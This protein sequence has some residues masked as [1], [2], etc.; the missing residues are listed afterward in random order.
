MAEGESDN[1]TME[2]YRALTRGNQASGIVKPKIRGNVNFEIKSQFMREL[3][4]NTFSE[5]KNDDAHEHVERVLDIVS[6]FNIQGVTHDGVML[7]VFPITLTGATKRYYPPSKTAKQLEEICNFKKEGEETLFQSWERYND[8]LYKCPTHD[9]NIHQKLTKEFQAKT[10][11][12]EPNSSVGQC[13]AVYANDEAPIDNK[14]YNGT[15]EVSFIANNKAHV[16]QEE[17]DV[18]IKVLSFQLP[19][20][21]LNPGSFT[22]P[23]TVGILNFFAMAD[24]G[25]SLKVMPKSMFEHL[26]VANRMKTD[27]L[28]EMDDMAN[29]API[30][31]VENVLVMIDMFLFLSDFVVID[32]LN[33]RNETMILE[34][35]FL[36]TIHIE[37][38]VFN[39]E[40][41]L[42]IR[43]DKER[44]SKKARMLKP[45]TNTS[46]DYKPRPRDYPFKE[47]LLTKVG[48]IDVSEPVKKALLK[49]WL[50]NCI[51]E[52]LAKDPRSRIFDDY[53][54]MFD[55]EIYQSAD[56]YEL[57]IGKKGHVLDDIWE[58]E[59]KKKAQLQKDKALNTKPSVQQSDRLPNTANGNKPKTRNFNQQPRNW[60]PSMSSRVSNRIV[61]TSELPRNQKPFLQS[62]DLE[63]STC[64]QCIFS[65]NHDECILK[66][67]SELNSRTS[68]QKKHAQS[69]KKTKRYIP[70][71]KKNNSKNHG[72]QIPIGQRFS[73]N[74]SSNV[75]LKTMPPR[76]GLTWKPTGRIFT[77]VG[78]KWISIRKSVET[79]YNTNNST[80]PL[81]KETHNPKT[82]IC[83]NSSSLSAGTS[84]AYEPISSEGSSN[85]ATRSSDKRFNTIITSLNALDESISSRN[86]VRK[87]LRALLT[88]WRPKDLEI[89]KRK[90]EKYKS[91]ALKERK[92]LSEEEGT[93]SDSDDEEYAMAEKDD[94]RCFKYGDQNH[95][96]SDSEGDCRKEEIC[97]MA[98][99]NSE[100]LSDTPY[101][102]SSSLDNE[103]WEMS[104]INYAKLVL[105]FSKK[106]LK[107]KNKVL[108]RKACELKAKVKQLERYKE[109]SLGCESCVDLQSKISL[110]TLKLA[111]FKN[112][113]SS[114]Q[115]MIEMQK[116][117]K[118]KH[119]LG[120][121]EV[122]AS[123]SS[124]KTKKSSIFLGYSPNSKAYI[125]LNKETMKVEESLNVK[126]DE[127]PPPV[128][129]PLE[130]DDILKCEVIE[131][132]VKD[133]E[134]K[135]NEP[136]NKEIINIKESKAHLLETVI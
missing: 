127:S 103:S 82:V 2:Q 43:D 72:R 126:F 48:H 63:C 106:Q 38:D 68:A 61:N 67:I 114:L 55:L 118:D 95:F 99:D 89:S 131:N 40:I 24:L 111:S 51:R 59:A 26:K 120:Y 75:F 5:N 37:I 16:A 28:V 87:F 64:K 4:E 125:I 71:E 47:W 69:H 105:E 129:P 15:N 41:S 58:N 27:I 133:L 65:A 12:E 85:I 6:L 34:R 1:L 39:K 56:E 49:S 122:I 92:V 124:I 11:S 54:W 44:S 123:S 90:K 10:A 132:K 52:E 46:K 91:L 20:K 78:I 84:M 9:I 19:P 42:G 94:Q 17:D 62:K 76:S 32:M 35:P 7:R 8:L 115:E 36:A 18:L 108:K 3:R 23:C 83:A 66:Y 136:L 57:G 81:G 45:D 22:L 21:E 73:L 135:E 117:P 77:Q 79:R 29:R 25:A 100:V 30:G 86:H 33:I 88:K 53:K 134:I 50:I 70:V 104:M 116:A 109:I 130:D 113:S 96:I 128:S 74:K 119:R 97:L 98:I 80:S 112:S 107:A 121:A 102:S 93:S 14:S 110:L 60:P 101:Y 13:K 31:I